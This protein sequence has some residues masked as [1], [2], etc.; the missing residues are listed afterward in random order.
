LAE[1]RQREGHSVSYPT[2]AELLHV[3]DYS[4]QANPKTLEGTQQA[5][6]DEQLEYIHR[7]AQRDLK[8]GRPVISVD[9]QAK[10]RVGDGKHGGREGQCQGQPEPVRVHDFALREP[11][12]GQVAP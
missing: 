4:L 2:V 5:D 11:G 8:Q 10:K 1:E 3:M 9:T 6:R 7:K 12:K